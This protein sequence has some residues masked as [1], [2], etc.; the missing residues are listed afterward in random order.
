MSVLPECTDSWQWRIKLTGKK[1]VGITEDILKVIERDGVDLTMC[2]GQGND[3]ASTMARVHLGVQARI[4]PIHCGSSVE[5]GFEPGTLRSRSRHLTI[6]GH[7]DT[8]VTVKRLSETRW[9]A[10]YEAVKP[11]F[12][13]FKKI[14]DAIEE[15]YYASETIETRGS[16]LLPSMCD[17]S[18][19]SF[20]CLWNNVLKEDNHV[21]NYLQILGIS[22]YKSVIEM[23][24]LKDS[25]KDKRCDLVEEA[26]E[27][28]KDTCEDMWIPIIKRRAV[29]RKKII[30]AE[31]AADEPL[32]LD[33]KLKRSMLE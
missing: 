13:C 29:R 15:L 20:L 25:L 8:E 9:S 10:H 7:R 4:G 31:K 28:A 1:A 12:K 3:S 5:S 6:I 18:F 22:F 14:V 27:F 17:F 23:R 16:T 2:R 33:Q 30:P 19:L 24:S 26:L 21:Q 11:M 32:T